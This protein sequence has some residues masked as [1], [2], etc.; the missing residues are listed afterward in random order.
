MA[1]IRKILWVPMLCALLGCTQSPHATNDG[2]VAEEAESELKGTWET[3]GV[4]PALGSVR[5]RMRIEEKGVLMMTLF[6]ET[7]GQRSFSGNWQLEGDELVLRGAYFGEDGQ[8][9]VR[10]QLEE[11]N[12]LVLEDEDGRQQ[13]W[14]R[15]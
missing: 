8:Q 12:R 3:Q 2:A 15:A 10:W 9:R 7:G 4:D 6:M 1:S 14:M 13:V 5:V 11:I